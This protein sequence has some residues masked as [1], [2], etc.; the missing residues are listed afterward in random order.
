MTINEYYE[1]RIR[2]NGTF[3]YTDGVYHSRAFVDI[4]EAYKNAVNDPIKRDV[5]FHPECEQALRDYWGPATT[6]L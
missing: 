5:V 2:P 1:V 4:W 6:T 3:G